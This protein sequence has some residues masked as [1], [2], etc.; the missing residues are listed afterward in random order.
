MLCLA[1]LTLATMVIAGCDSQPPCDSSTRVKRALEAGDYADACV[2]VQLDSSGRRQVTVEWG[3]PN[4]DPDANLTHAKELKNIVF[5]TWPDGVM[6]V[7]VR[8]DVGDGETAIPTVWFG[9]NVAR[10]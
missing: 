1:G 10:P 4:H 7:K 2:R 3:D 9:G 8:L 5:S 6:E